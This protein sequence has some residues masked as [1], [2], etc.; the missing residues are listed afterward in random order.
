MQPSL[1][2]SEPHYKQN[3]TSTI[4]LYLKKVSSDRNAMIGASTPDVQPKLPHATVISMP[5]QM[6]IMQHDRVSK[7]T[8]SI[9]ID[10]TVVGHGS[11][12]A[13]TG[14]HTNKDFV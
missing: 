11:E 6:Q 8:D 9:L 14:R 3:L 10:R 13:K 7:P 1:F 4:K 12:I 2:V 5:I